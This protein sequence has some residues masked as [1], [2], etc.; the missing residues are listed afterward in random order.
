M[1]KIKDLTSE[2]IFDLYNKAFTFRHDH[3]DHVSSLLESARKNNAVAPSGSEIFHPELWK[4]MH[5]KWFTE[6]M[7]FR[8]E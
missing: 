5:W 3:A 2:E 8:K 4:S 7:I 1:K 6:N